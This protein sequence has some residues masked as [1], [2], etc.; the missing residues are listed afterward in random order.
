MDLSLRRISSDTISLDTLPLGLRLRKEVKMV[1]M[2]PQLLKAAVFGHTEEEHREQQD[3]RRLFHMFDAD[4]NNLLDYDEVMKL[5]QNTHGAL[6]G[7]ETAKTMA[8]ISA[9][10]LKKGS[11]VSVNFD[12]FY[13]WNYM[14]IKGRPLL[15]WPKDF[16]NI[17]ACSMLSKLWTENDTVIPKGCYGEKLYLLLQ[18]GCLSYYSRK[19]GDRQSMQSL[20]MTTKNSTAKRSTL[21][22]AITTAAKGA[23]QWQIDMDHS[24]VEADAEIPMV[25]M[26]A[27]LS[28]EEKKQ[29]DTSNFVVKAY[30]PTQTLEIGHLAL[31]QILMDVW[32]EGA[33]HLKQLIG[34][35]YGE[36]SLISDTYESQA[37]TFMRSESG[38]QYEMSK[39]LDYLCE[40]Q[41]QR[42]PGLQVNS[43]NAVSVMA[44]LCKKVES[45]EANMEQLMQG[46]IEILSV[47]RDSRQGHVP[48]GNVLAN[49]RQAV[50]PAMFFLGDE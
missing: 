45:L 46:Q 35:H 27:L 22:S 5:L 1:V 23:K 36:D 12:Q 30:E 42:G 28:A 6:E 50:E 34:L 47:L 41:G 7:P 25:G 29:V 24:Y 16:I 38:D 39:A 44:G 32:P 13:F 9:M 2:G 40:N 18:F 19:A 43:K 31:R 26:T 21:L 3:L 33:R 37:P 10:G 17:L 8:A 49:D 20:R 11:N 48:A 15:K 14:S 4:K